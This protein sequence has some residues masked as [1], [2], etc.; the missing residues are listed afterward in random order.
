MVAAG[1]RL[2]VSGAVV[3]AEDAT[4]CFYRI[5]RA[6]NADA[7]VASTLYHFDVDAHHLFLVYVV[8]GFKHVVH[9]VG[10]H[11]ANVTVGQLIE[12]VS[13]ATC[14]LQQPPCPQQTKVLRNK[15]LADADLFR[16]VPYRSWPLQARRY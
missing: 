9:H 14:L 13:S 5:A 8:F 7:I 15:A 10:Q 12:D 4:I 3:A 2:V 16:K 11:G 1:G 6:D